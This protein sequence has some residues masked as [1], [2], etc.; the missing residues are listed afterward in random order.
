M[1]EYLILIFCFGLLLFIKFFLFRYSNDRKM[2]FYTDPEEFCIEF[3]QN[4]NKQAAQNP[5][6]KT[7]FMDSKNLL[8]VMQLNLNKL[9]ESGNL[10][11]FFL[12]KS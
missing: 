11:I 2:S 12:P 9:A 1:Q 7:Q 3:L 8:Q 10:C 4:L 6:I 5:I